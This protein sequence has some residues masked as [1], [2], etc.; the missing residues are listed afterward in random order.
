ML[1]KNLKVD[2]LKKFHSQFNEDVFVGLNPFNVVKSRNSQGGTGFVQ[3]EKEVKNW[4]KKLI[5]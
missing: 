3:V 4:Q 5:L 1:F 2:E